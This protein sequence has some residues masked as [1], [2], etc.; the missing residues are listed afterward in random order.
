MLLVVFCLLIVNFWQVVTVRAVWYFSS[1]L[2]LTPSKYIVNNNRRFVSSRS[3]HG[4]QQNHTMVGPPVIEGS[5]KNTIHALAFGLICATLTVNFGKYF[6]PHFFP[7]MV[8]ILIAIE[9]VL[10]S[11]DKPKE[12]YDKYQAPGIRGSHTIEGAGSPQIRVS[13]PGEDPEA[14]P[15]K[16]HRIKDKLKTKKDQKGRRES[17]V[18]G[19]PNVRRESGVPT[20]SPKKQSLA[21]PLSAGEEALEAMNQR[22]MEHDKGGKDKSEKEKKKEEDKAKKKEKEEEKERQK[23][24]KKELKEKGKEE[25]TE[26]S[27]KGGWRKRKAT[28]QDTI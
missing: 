5:L 12:N 2:Y 25:D 28:K 4:D 14:S 20:G 6:V 8:G 13:A 27:E 9:V 3:L 23:A 18:P 10:F 22:E 11:F 1:V 15:R 7:Y 21:P 19:S 26:K 16:Q 17:G 24:E